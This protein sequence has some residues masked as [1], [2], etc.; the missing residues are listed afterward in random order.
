MLTD[1]T[2]DIDFNLLFSSDLNL[3]DD[4]TDSVHSNE[5]LKVIH[6]HKD[7]YLYLTSPSQ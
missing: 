7:K 4:D 1:I 5:E 2:A 3:E 6:K